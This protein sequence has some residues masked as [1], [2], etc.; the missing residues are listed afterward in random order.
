MTDPVTPRNF[1][2]IWPALRML[3]RLLVIGAVAL[4]AHYL[5]NLSMDMAERLP[6]SQPSRMQSALLVAA[7]IVYA[8]LIATPFVP[9]VEIGLALLLLRGASIAP[10]VY[11][12]TVLGLTFAYLLGRYLK[13]DALSRF[14]LD[15][16]LKRAGQY[17]HRLTQMPPRDREAELEARLPD[18]LALPLVR[19]RYLSLALLLNLPG[20]VVLGGGGGLMIMA[21]LSRLYHTARTI[22]TIAL[23]VLPVPLMI[24]WFGTGMFTL[25][26][27]H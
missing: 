26:P 16:G 17:V 4:L 11:G 14:L 22:L 27:A 7:L 15:L 20:N 8:L 12:A 25:P 5:L 3:R 18:W 19:Y 1:Q 9:G 6:E 13:D 10:A 24:W 23:A 21:G 2:W